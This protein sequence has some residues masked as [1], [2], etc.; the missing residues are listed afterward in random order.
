MIR[1]NRREAIDRKSQN[2]GGGGSFRS[3]AFFW[4][5]RRGTRVVSIVVSA[6][7][8]VQRNF[9][10]AH[11]KITERGGGGGASS[12]RTR[13][14]GDG[15]ARRV[16]GGGASSSRTRK[17]GDGLTRLE[18]TTSVPPH[19]HRT[20]KTKTKNMKPAKPPLGR[21]I[22]FFVSSKPTFRHWGIASA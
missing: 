20:E 22:V 18:D 19:L 11:S 10:I 3:A 17:A 2:G 15:M 1:K 8:V 6:I 14:A 13:I 16:G 21:N 5:Q 7:T 9:G 4:R 12:S